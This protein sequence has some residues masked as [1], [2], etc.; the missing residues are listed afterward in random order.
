[1]AESAFPRAM[2]LDCQFHRSLVQA[3]GN[4]LLE[5]LND[6]LA[7]L[8]RESRRKTMDRPGVAESAVQMHWKIFEAV[9]RHDPERAREAMAKHL[10]QALEVW[11]ER[12]REASSPDSANYHGC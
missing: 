2:E 6:S 1:M 9:E 12:R 8:L 4:G 10:Q 3:S 5:A 7:D 11:S